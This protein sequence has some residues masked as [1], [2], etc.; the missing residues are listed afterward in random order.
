MNS[1]L[2]LSVLSLL[3]LGR[4]KDIDLSEKWYVRIPN[5]YNITPDIILIG[6]HHHRS[7]DI[8]NGNFRQIQ[9]EGHP[10][11]LAAFLTLHI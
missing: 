2:K 3:S 7:K 1:G 8:R 6:T 11:L 9:F 4:S 5:E 10:I